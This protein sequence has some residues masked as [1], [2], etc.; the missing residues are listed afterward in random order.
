MPVSLFRTVP[1]LAWDEGNLYQYADWIK[2]IT[3]ILQV[4]HGQS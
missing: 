3:N 1:V 4:W 2:H